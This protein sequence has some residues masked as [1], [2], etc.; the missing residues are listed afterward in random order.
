M[1]GLRTSR[2]E[3]VRTALAEVA[4][5]A[6]VLDERLCIVDRTDEAERLVGAPLPLGVSAPKVL[7]GERLER[8]VADA[9]AEGRPISAKVPR[10]DPTG[11]PGLLSVRAMPLGEGDDRVGWLLLLEEDDLAEEDPD[12][13]VEVEGILTRDPA[14]K[15]LLR[16]MRK[17]A[18]T[19]ASVLVR[20]ETGSGKELVARALHALS[21][22]ASGPFR[23]LNCAALPPALLESE[24]FGHVRGAFT[25]AVRDQK[26]HVQL[27]HGGTLFL[28]EVAELPLELQAKL[29][30][31]LQEKTVLPVG[32]RE[33]IAVDVRFVSATHRALRREVEAGRFR[34]DLMFRLRVIPLFLPPLR[35]RRRDIELLA[36]RFIEERNRSG[37]RHVARIAPGALRALSTYDWPGNVR[38]LANA[39]EYAFVM[40]EGPILV[41]PD[42]PLE[43]RGE[44]PG[45]AEDVPSSGREGAMRT[46]ELSPEAEKVIAALEKAG[47]NRQKAAASLGISRVTLWRRMRA[48]GLEDSGAEG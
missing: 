35:A 4:G 9:L 45:Y 31:V 47:G 16:D 26:G 38:E 20:G 24:L 41:E 48:L 8:P 36:W 43:V 33:P 27:A 42:L 3:I 21:P 46:P 34:A 18:R 28:D 5:A 19:T 17:V 32:G 23:A 12:A 10:P 14:M 29:L 13:P 44:A 37:E 25:G 2:E 39:I 40:G 11:K 15:K 1:K 22:R 7:C 30:R 6:V